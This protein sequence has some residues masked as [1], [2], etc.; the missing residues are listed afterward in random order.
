MPTAASKK[1][2]TGMMKPSM[3]MEKPKRIRVKK[4]EK[5]D[6]QP[7]EEVKAE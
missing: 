2:E 6:A 4:E 3:D 1:L 5:V 7:A